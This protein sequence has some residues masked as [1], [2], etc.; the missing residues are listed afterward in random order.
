M[1]SAGARPAEP[2]KPNKAPKIGELMS[3]TKEYATWTGRESK[4][5]WSGLK[6]EVATYA[7]PNC[8]HY[9]MSDPKK[10]Y[11]SC[12]EGLV[13]KFERKGNLLTFTDEVWEHLLGC[14]LDTSAYVQDPVE[15]YKMTYVV[16]NHVCFMLDSIKVKKKDQ[17]AKYDSY[18]LDN[19]KS[20]KEFVLASLTT[21]FCQ[22]IRDVIHKKDPFPVLWILIIE[23][24]QSTSVENFDD[25]KDAIKCL[26]PSGFDD[27][28]LKAMMRDYRLLARELT[29]AGQYD[30]QA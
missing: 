23:K 3:L 2:P 18:D 11:N 5:D 24:I 30:C 10:G 6:D 26:K 20:A 13:T 12:H 29:T 9:V 19:N 22:A 8:L 14:G 16:L 21:D 28:N 7:S 25:I 1:P 17:E 27:E 15:D 4:S